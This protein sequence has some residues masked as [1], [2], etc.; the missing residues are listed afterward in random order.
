MEIIFGRSLN[1][2]YITTVNQFSVAH[3]PLK[4]LLAELS[5]RS[6]PLGTGVAEAQEY[7]LFIAQ[8]QTLAQ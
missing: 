3:N 1:S 2:R 6:E 8:T 4:G 7:I 5:R